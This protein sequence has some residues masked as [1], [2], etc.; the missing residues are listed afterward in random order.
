L[1]EACVN[2][3]CYAVRCMKL[4]K[5]TFFGAMKAYSNRKGI[6]GGSLAPS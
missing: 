1:Y 5:V 3:S 6:F 4:L 2:M